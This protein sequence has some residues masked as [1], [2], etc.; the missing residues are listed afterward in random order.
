[1]FDQ[2]VPAGNLSMREMWDK[3]WSV[4]TTSTFMI[5][6]ALVPLLLKS[7]DPRLLFVTSG[8]STLTEHSNPALAI[9]KAPPKG[10]PKPTFFIPAYRSSKAGMNMMMLEWSRI[11]EEDGVKVWAISP[12]HLATG[13]G[14]SVERN[15]QMGAQDPALGGASIKDVV[16]GKRD[17][18]VGKAIRR[19][20]VQPW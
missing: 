6:Q 20:G 2:L 5:T 18:D 16:E 11:L 10:W 14:G 9:N 15:K 1:M 8:T 17:G 12:G 4:N 3:S 19:D 13:L 7:S